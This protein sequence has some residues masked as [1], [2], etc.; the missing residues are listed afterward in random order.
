MGFFNNLTLTFAFVALLNFYIDQGYLGVSYPL[1][2]EKVHRESEDE[3]TFE[4]SK[5]NS[6]TVLKAVLHYRNVQG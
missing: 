6:K 5:F 3:L 4:V 2:K 1:L